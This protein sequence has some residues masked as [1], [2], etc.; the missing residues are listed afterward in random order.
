M[1]GSGV[2]GS[3]LDMEEEIDGGRNK[4]NRKWTVVEKRKRRKDWSQ[5]SGTESEGEDSQ[6]RR[7]KEE[8]KVLVKFSSEAVNQ[9]NPLKLTKALKETI[10]IIEGA[11]ILRDGKMIVFCKD[12][13]QQKAAVGIK[14]LVGQKVTCSVVEGKKWIRG[15]ISGIPIDISADVIKRN[16]SGATVLEARRLKYTRNKERLDS[17]SVML[18]FDEEK[19]P[20]RV[21]LGAMSYV[22]RLFIP[23]PLRCFKC[24]KFGHVAAV[25][26]GKQ[27]CARCGGEHEYGGCEE[28]VKPKCCNCGGDHSAGYGGCQVRKSAAMVQNVKVVEGITYAEAIKRVKDTEKAVEKI[29]V[30]PK[31]REENTKVGKQKECVLIEDRLAFL[32]FIAE[33]V[34]CSAQTESRTER[35]KIIIRAA[36]KYLSIDGVTVEQVNEKLNVRT[37]NTQTEHG[38]A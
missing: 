21:F 37:N 1:E 5:T 33:V 14:T 36:D 31:I 28:G 38:G 26:R 34:N 20:S 19:M 27:R 12:S 23:P 32:T 29:A 35:I 6:S 16:I 11:K 10:G 18:R 7:S 13:K 17:L 30:L 9:M 8:Y 3:D 15:V 4:V 24:Q 2:A 25:C 22:V